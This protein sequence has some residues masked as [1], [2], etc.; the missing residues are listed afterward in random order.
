MELL[1]DNNAEHI[2][3]L[4]DLCDNIY[5]NYFSRIYENTLFSN[6]DY[7]EII[8]SISRELLLS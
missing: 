2:Q 4:P 6:Y 5:N 3:A 1:T 8:N 7:Q